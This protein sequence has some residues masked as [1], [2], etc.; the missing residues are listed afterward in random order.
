MSAS[1]TS[2]LPVPKNKKRSPIK[3]PAQ[4]RSRETMDNILEAMEELLTEKPFDKITIQEIAQ[5]SGSGVSS[6]YAR[7]R[8]KQSLVLGVHA[9]IRE[10]VLE[11]VEEMS[12]PERWKDTPTEDIVTWVV[13]FC[14]KW[15]RDHGPFIRAAISI[16]EPELRER[17]ASV[18][19]FAASKFTALLAPRYPKHLEA[20]ESAVDG[21]VRMLTSVMYVSL[22]FGGVQ[23][24]RKPL[25]DKAVVKLLVQSINAILEGA[26]KG[27]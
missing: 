16:D 23:M 9:R 4:A 14:V 12:D 1:K 18:L 6:I 21:S 27:D 25:S 20:L 3:A 8:D 17:Q 5:R 15:Y 11:C 13:T 7:F 22:I 26:K 19:K 2:T 24:S 10:G